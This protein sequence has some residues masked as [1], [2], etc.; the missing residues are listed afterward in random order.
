MQLLFNVLIKNL[1]QALSFSCDNEALTSFLPLLHGFT[2]VILQIQHRP[3]E[4]VNA[5]LPR[6]LTA[7]K[8]AV[9]E[10]ADK[11]TKDVVAG[12]FERVTAISMA[13]QEVCNKQ[14][15]D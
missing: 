8:F 4:N 3:V 7:G 12:I 14:V 13:L 10:A 1:V 6:I 5:A 15:V 11:D 9:S 2:I